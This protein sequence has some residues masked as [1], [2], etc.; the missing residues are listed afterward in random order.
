MKIEIPNNATN[1]EV[2][3]AL[4]PKASIRKDVLGNIWITSPYQLGTITFREVW[5][6]EPYK[7]NKE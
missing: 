2:I 3:K 1:G 6:E 4:F 7:E 5:W